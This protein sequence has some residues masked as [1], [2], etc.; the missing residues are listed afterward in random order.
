MQK[1]RNFYVWPLLA[2]LLLTGCQGRTSQAGVASSGKPTAASTSS[3]DYWLWVKEAQTAYADADYQTALDDARQAIRLDPNENTAW[4]L[5]TQALIAQAGDSYLS[6]LPDHR[7]QLPVDI[8]VRDRVNH[9]REWFIVDVRQPDE[10]AAG[11][12][13]GAINL[14]LGELLQNLGELPDSKTAPILLYCHS[15]KRATHALVILHELGYLK[16][17]NLEGGYASYE[18]WMNKNPIPTPGPT[19]TPG[20]DEPDLGC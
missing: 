11:H 6:K 12:I 5:Y 19:P 9:S 16:V 1:L 14:P 2:V 18:D 3:G 7:Y 17:F 13:E 15:Q 10:Y 4:E 20:P 8:F